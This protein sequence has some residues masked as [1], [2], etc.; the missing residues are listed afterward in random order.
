MYVSGK[1]EFVFLFGHLTDKLIACILSGS[2]IF[3]FH[4]S[5]FTL[6]FLFYLNLCEGLDDITDLDVVEVDE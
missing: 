2:K 1:S 6:K 3:T 5:L 4:S